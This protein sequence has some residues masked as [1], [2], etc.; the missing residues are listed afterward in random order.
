MSERKQGTP[1]LP[2]RDRFWAALRQIA[3][4]EG[5]AGLSRTATRLAR[6]ALAEAWP[7]PD[8][9]C[10]LCGATVNV[11]SPDGGRTHARPGAS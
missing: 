1:P 2:E 4:G 3:D 11:A 8:G 7:M 6:E 10:P 5:D 9:A